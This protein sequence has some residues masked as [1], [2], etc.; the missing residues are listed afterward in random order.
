MNPDHIVP[1]EDYSDETIRSLIAHLEASSSFEHFIYRESEL[2]A[3]W[4]LVEIALQHPAGTAG[5]GE[6]A[7]LQRLLAAAREAH[8][9]VADEQPR[10]AAERLRQVL[11]SR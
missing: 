11:P 5:A 3:V 8:D 1:V 6:S 9:L 2:D 7:R 10:E 4:R